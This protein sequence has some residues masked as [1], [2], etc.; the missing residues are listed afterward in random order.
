MRTFVGSD[1]KA[2]GFWY[3]ELRGSS[4]TVTFGRV[5]TGG[6]T[7]HKAFD[8]EDAARKGY[9][10]AIAE[11]LKKGYKETTAKTASSPLVAS[12]EAALV[13]NPD[14]LAA[15]SAY[16]DYLAEQGDPR[17]ELIQLQL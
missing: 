15:H 8:D 13:E 5:G 1:G 2:H 3:I 9:D 11:K 14:D 10:R 7:Q 12:L 16:A 6:Q 17:G 4:Y